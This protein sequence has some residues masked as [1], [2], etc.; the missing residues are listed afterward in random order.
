VASVY[1]I[2]VYIYCWCRWFHWLMGDTC[3]SHTNVKLQQNDHLSRYLCCLQIHRLTWQWHI[4]AAWKQVVVYWRRSYRTWKKH[5]P[6]RNSG[7]MKEQLDSTQHRSPIIC[8][9]HVAFQVSNNCLTTVKIYL[10][11]QLHPNKR[12]IFK[13][14]PR[15]MP[16][17]GTACPGSGRYAVYTAYKR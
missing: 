3:I 6:C 13:F 15:W 4:W 9:L 2:I 10:D 5:G 11:I 12:N 14:N 16:W 7:M 1:C 8:C 17:K